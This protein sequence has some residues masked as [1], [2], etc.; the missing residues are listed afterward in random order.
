[1]KKYAIFVI[2]ILAI[3][4]LA[5]GCTDNP[6]TVST[7]IYS[8]NGISFNYPESW[9]EIKNIKTANAIVDYGD[10]NSVDAATG[11]VNTLVL[12]Q[13]VPLPAGHT[14][15]QS[16]DATYAQ[17]AASNSSHQQISDK[18]I[19]VNGQTAYEKT[20][21]ISAGGVTKQERVVWLEKNGIIY[22][23]LCGTL[24]D[25]FN[26]QQANFDAI[27]NSFKITA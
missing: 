25:T 15:K 19:N 22:V 17:Y 24:P 18:T 2:A 16:Y 5:F 1:M 14:L 8:F 26:A 23:I 21:K 7:K 13:K 12:I 4:V 27:I 20:H 6:L 10:P 3:I 11:S 9:E